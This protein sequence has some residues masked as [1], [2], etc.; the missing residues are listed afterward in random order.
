MV[1]DFEGQGA[2]EA[3]CKS[4]IVHA[5]DEA[6]GFLELGAPLKAWE[7]IESLPPADRTHPEVVFA[8]SRDRSRA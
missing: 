1:R 7:I 3:C 2:F 5:F 4:S 6:R 8:A